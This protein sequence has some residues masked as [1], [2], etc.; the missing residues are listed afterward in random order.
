MN[1]YLN[2]SVNMGSTKVKY[3]DGATFVLERDIPFGIEMAKEMGF[4]LKASS[5]FTDQI[6]HILSVISL[7]DRV[8][9]EIILRV[10][11][12]SIWF[13]E[14]LSRVSY[15]HYYTANKKPHVTIE[16]SFDNAK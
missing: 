10:P 6:E 4:S 12:F 1:S 15:A 16:L 5:L 9:T 8:P 3:F 14:A 13:K 11:Q 2:I 7:Y